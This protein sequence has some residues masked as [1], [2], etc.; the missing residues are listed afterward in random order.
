M[1]DADALDK[2]LALDVE[3]SY[4]RIAEFT[5]VNLDDNVAYSLWFD[6]NKALWG[7]SIKDSPKAEMTVEERA[8]FFKSDIF[9]KIAKKTYFRLTAA[10]DAFYSIVDEHL[11]NAELLLVDTV[12]LSAILH[13]LDT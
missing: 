3:N 9:K 2:S 11:K 5:L 1:I 12:K 6:N 10:K 7:V 4:L 8:D 13:F